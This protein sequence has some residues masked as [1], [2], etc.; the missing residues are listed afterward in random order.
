M[1]VL[2]ALGEPLLPSAAITLF[3]LELSQFASNFAQTLL[4]FCSLANKCLC[5]FAR[6][7]IQWLDSYGLLIARFA[8]L[9]W[10]THGLTQLFHLFLQ[11][12]HNLPLIPTKLSWFSLYMLI[13]I[14]T[15]MQGREHY[16]RRVIA[17]YSCGPQDFAGMQGFAPVSQPSHPYLPQ[18]ASD[19]I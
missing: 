6:Q 16:G 11:K 15:K 13:S 17:Y 18:R 7:E 3:P 14:P 5:Q 8:G 19:S 4:V 12:F 10:C 1:A 9:R 2:H